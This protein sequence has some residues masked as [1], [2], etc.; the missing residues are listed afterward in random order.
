[1]VITW[2]KEREKFV[3]HLLFVCWCWSVCFLDEFIIAWSYAH[4]LFT[5]A[6]E[7]ELQHRSNWN[8]WKKQLIFTKKS[9]YRIFLNEKSALSWFFSRHSSTSFMRVGCNPCSSNRFLR[10]KIIAVAI[11]IKA[12]R[13]FRVAV[14]ASAKNTT[15]KTSPSFVHEAHS[16]TAHLH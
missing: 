16:R 6:L 10:F 3:S 2:N 9:A 12:G 13:G 4:T 5:S 11:H 14:R 1:M 15:H 7:S 8:L